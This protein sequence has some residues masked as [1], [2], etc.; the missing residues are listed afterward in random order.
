MLKVTYFEWINF[1][2]LGSVD[3]W[4]GAGTALHN[5]RPLKRQP[6]KRAIFLVETCVHSMFKIGRPGDLGTIRPFLPLLL[7][8]HCHPMKEENS[9]KTVNSKQV[10]QYLQ[11][12]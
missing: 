5:T 12:I 4:G 7:P 3:K 9:C 8:E 10:F 1:G 6:N 11:S 2:D